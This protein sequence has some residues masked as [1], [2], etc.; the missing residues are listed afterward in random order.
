MYP[1]IPETTEPAII[2]IFAEFI[3]ISLLTNAKPP[4]NSDIVKPT[5]DSIATPIISMKFVCLGNVAIFNLILKYENSETPIAFPKNSDK[6][7]LK[8]KETSIIISL[9]K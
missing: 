9:E 6:D 8:A 7:I 3:K 1:T 2:P 5:P 4:I